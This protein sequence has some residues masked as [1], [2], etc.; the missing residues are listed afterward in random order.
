MPPFYRLFQY[1]AIYF[2]LGLG[3]IAAALIKE[4]HDV[5]ILH[6]DYDPSFK[7]K[8]HENLFRNYPMFRQSLDSNDLLCWTE[9][10][11]AI[12]SFK[13]DLV[14]TTALTVYLQSAWKV[15]QIA[16]QMSQDITTVIGGPD[17]TGKP[18]DS[19]KSP[20]VDYAISGEGEFVMPSLVRVLQRRDFSRLQTIPG[21]SYRDGNRV[22]LCKSR[23]PNVDVRDIP[24]PARNSLSF[25]QYPPDIYGT[26]ITERGCPYHCTF[27]NSPQLWGSTMRY[28]DIQ[29]VLDEIQ[30]I[31]ERFGTT[32]YRFYDDVFGLNRNRIKRLLSGLIDRK[33]QIRYWCNSRFDVLDRELLDLMVKSGC[34]ELSLGIESG[35]NKI[36]KYVKKNITVEKIKNC[37][38]TLKSS[39]IGWSAFF[40]MG[41]P[42]ETEEDLKLT[43]R[44]ME[45]VDPPKGIIFS[46]F[47]PYPGTELY[48]ECCRLGLLPSNVE[49]WSL[50]SHQSLDTHFLLSIPKSLFQA[51]VAK[52][53]A[54]AECK[55][56]LRS[57]C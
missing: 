48:E 6:A 40:I 46:I 32:Y 13:P 27:C 20:W 52:A 7:S 30:Y 2:P 16:K 29:G 25:K 42:L 24:P 22:I 39:E 19:M 31:Y 41:F 26:I 11:A 17:V 45:E 15:L 56:P 10:K 37:L 51:Y 53:I 21:I 28:H 18:E 49:L 57:I 36:L 38:P 35:S 50:Y 1:P 44:L 4:E 43:L 14:G 3:Y 23:A 33:I 8:S 54:I 34:D 9:I 55:R 12:S 47:T 5:R